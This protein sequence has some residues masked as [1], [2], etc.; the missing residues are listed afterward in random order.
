MRQVL[1]LFGMCMIIEIASSGYAAE[2]SP[3]RLAGLF[4]INPSEAVGGF[5]WG[6]NEDY[7]KSICTLNSN[8]RY[9]R[10]YSPKALEASFKKMGYK[11]ISYNDC[12]TVRW[13]EVAL[14]IVEL[15]FIE[16]K[17]YRTR[18][19]SQLDFKQSLNSHKKVLAIDRKIRKSIPG[20]YTR[21]ISGVLGML[22]K[23]SGQRIGSSIV[24]YMKE[25]GKYATTYEGDDSYSH[26][27]ITFV[28]DVGDDLPIVKMKVEY[29][30]T[31]RFKKYGE[32]SKTQNM[33]YNI[34]KQSK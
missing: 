5:R 16:G 26:I 13:H 30:D 33:L 25:S 15:D 20:H 8:D 31:S 14:N 24:S 18:L 23:Y 7:A 28:N 32:V 34:L 17:L 22:K 9:L 19:F 1:S 29:Y 6:G 12:G 4:S 27:F 11:Y 3:D 2:S 10:E 21:P